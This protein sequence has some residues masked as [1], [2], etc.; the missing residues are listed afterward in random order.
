MGIDAMVVERH[1]DFPNLRTFDQLF[2][3]VGVPNL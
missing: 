2:M 3:L 1:F